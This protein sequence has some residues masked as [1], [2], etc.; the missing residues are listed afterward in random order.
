MCIRDSLAVVGVMLW[1]GGAQAL[2]YGLAIFFVQAVAGLVA[3]G[4]AKAKYAEYL[5]KPSE[6]ISPRN[7]V[8]GALVLFAGS[9]FVRALLDIETSPDESSSGSFIEGATQGLIVGL[10]ISP[11]VIG[12]ATFLKRRKVDEEDLPR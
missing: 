3:I 12:I 1:F 10:V 5:P 7:L 9:G 6:L 11:I 4:Y 8:Y 2:P